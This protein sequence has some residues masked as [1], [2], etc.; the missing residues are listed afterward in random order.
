MPDPDG[1][2]F[3]PTLLRDGEVKGSSV[4]LLLPDGFATPIWCRDIPPDGGPTSV[5]NCFFKTFLQED[6]SVRVLW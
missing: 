6:G 5:F 2:W 4:G 3:M 1:K